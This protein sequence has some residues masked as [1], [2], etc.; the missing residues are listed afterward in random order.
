MITFFYLNED[1]MPVWGYNFGHVIVTLPS[2]KQR[3]FADAPANDIL[4]HLDS[5]RIRLAHFTDSGYS[6]RLRPEK[7]GPP[8]G[9][10]VNIRIL[11]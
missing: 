10:D 6:L 7:D 5:M 2:L 8:S 11:G 9:K 3:H 1:Y 4:T